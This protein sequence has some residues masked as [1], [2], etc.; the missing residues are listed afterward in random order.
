MKNVIFIAP[1]AA[2]KGTQAK[3]LCQKYGFIHISTGDLL[4]KAARQDSDIQNKL[5]LGTLIDDSIILELIDKEICALSDENGYVL[6]GFPRN[7]SQ[8]KAFDQMIK[9]FLN[10]SYVVIYIDVSKEIASERIL[11][12]LYCPDCGASYNALL[13][14][15]QPKK[16]NECDRCHSSL[17][18]RDDDTPSTFQA[19]FDAYINHTEPLL[20]YYRVHQVLYTVNGN[21]DS[22][23]VHA[24]IIQILEGEL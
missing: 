6:D 10:S 3:M 14:D 15:N 4:R 13:P 2:G 20:E 18:K 21:Q 22:L 24:D 12:R 11:G 17:I 1:P 8:A 16:Q 19:R 23:K 7:I 5:N 9:G